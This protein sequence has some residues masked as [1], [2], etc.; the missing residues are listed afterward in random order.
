[1][2]TSNKT[3]YFSASN[4]YGGFKSYY[5]TVFNPSDF[6]HLYVIKGGSGTGKSY[7]MKY[8]AQK[9]AEAGYECEYVYC[10]SDPT[11]L[12]GAIFRNGKRK[13]GI[14]DGTAPHTRCLS[15]PGVI[16]EI[17]NLGMFWDTAKLKEHRNE[18]I[19][20]IEEKKECYENAYAMLG[21]AGKIDGVES[22]IVKK[23]I[24]FD[25]MHGAAER[26]L[27]KVRK[28]NSREKRIRVIS[29]YGMFG[30]YRFGTYENLA[31]KVYVVSDE[32][33]SARFFMSE[34]VKILES[35]GVSYTYIPS[36]ES[37]NICEGV[38]IDSTKT[39]ILTNKRGI[40][41]ENIY[42][43]I[44][45]HRFLYTDVLSVYRKDIRE[46]ENAKRRFI[47]DASDCLKSAGDL[48]FRLEGIY[49]SAMDF[50]AKE[51]Y[52]EQTAQKVISMLSE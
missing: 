9:C 14:L 17:L 46:L 52:T 43:K 47:S 10:S 23:C 45:M 38:Y 50:D 29:A 3:E 40:S 25:K 32:Y 41:E 37:E 13:V 39:A 22:G 4:G 8:I 7:T 21:I 11:S 33:S 30:T 48:H 5:D 42:K 27:A 26:L 49:S 2:K 18:I 36:P 12:D 28:T 24:D 44:N 6:T 35:R 20:I 31:Q 15:Y 51:K 16:D 1:M 19:Q 34:I